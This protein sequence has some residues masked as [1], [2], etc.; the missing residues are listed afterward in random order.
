MPALLRI[1]SG[2]SAGTSYWIDRSVLRVGSDPGCEVCLPTA[3]L[4]AHAVTLEFRE[5]AYKLYNRGLKSISVGGKSVAS[6]GASQWTGDEPLELPG[7][8]RLVLQ[9]DGNP[10][11]CP[12]PGEQSAIG[13]YDDGDA[14]GTGDAARAE[15]GRANAPSAAK[16][17]MLTQIAVIGFCIAGCVML[18]AFRGQADDQAANVKRLTFDE[19]VASA[20]AGDPQARRL[21]AHLQLAQAAIVRGH[22]DLARARFADL[23][24]KLIRE[25][26]FES[27][28][29]TQNAEQLLEGELRH[30]VLQYVESRLIQLQ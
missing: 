24:D 12:P 25:R 19:L 23:R 9:I 2:I 6:G 29:S 11:P 30:Q 20:P 17:K 16:S 21:V 4:A 7:D 1:E 10:A 8:I 27:K 28:A 26:D 3:E 22:T 18:I 15:N 5:G 14:G 13:A